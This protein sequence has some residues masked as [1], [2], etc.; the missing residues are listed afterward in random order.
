MATVIIEERGISFEALKQQ[1]RQ[2]AGKELAAG[3]LRTAGKHKETGAD[4]VDIAHWNEYG[5]SRIPKRPFMRIAASR[6]EKNWGILAEDA[7]EK[8]IDGMG[9]EQ[10]VDLLGN[11]MVGD[12]K[13]VIG[14]KKLL[15]PNAPSTIRMKT[16]RGKVGDAPLIDTGQL[17]QSISFEVR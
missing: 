14:D 11:Q 8:V 17:R 5:T 15:R 3:V 1:A 2:L 10:A 7:A 13:E 9:V 6:N 16:V 12:I 4:L